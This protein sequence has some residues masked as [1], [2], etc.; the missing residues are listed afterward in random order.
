MIVA[1][2]RPMWRRQIEG[3]AALRDDRRATRF[4]L[5]QA[6]QQIKRAAAPPRQFGDQ[7]H[8]DLPRLR[9]GHHLLPL[10]TVGLCAGTGLPSEVDTRRAGLER[11]QIA[12]GAS[13]RFPMRSQAGWAEAPVAGR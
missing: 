8:I 1:I 9:E 2:M 5:R 7:H 10:D 11:L 13:V 12:Q 6:V 4:Q 3:E